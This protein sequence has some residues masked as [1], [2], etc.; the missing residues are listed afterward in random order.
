[1]I[2]RVLFIDS[3]TNAVA[4]IQD[5]LERTGNYEAAVFST[6]QAA[7]E[8]AAQHPPTV[9]V[10]ALNLRDITVPTLA[11]QLRR[12]QPDLP[13]IVRATGTGH[14]QLI[15]AL[16]PRGVIRGGYSVR[17]LTALLKKALQPS[18]PK[19]GA[20][21]PTDLTAG[22][23]GED[24][25]AFGEV[26]Q[27]I[28]PGTPGGKEDT[29]KAL[30]DWMR[31]PPEKKPPLPER[32]RRSLANMLLDISKG[33]D[34]GAL[35]EEEKSAQEKLFARLAAE[36][37]PMPTLEESGTVRDLI[38]IADPD[39]V[40]TPTPEP[41]AVPE[42]MIDVG[43]SLLDWSDLPEPFEEDAA[44]NTAAAVLKAL[45]VPPLPTDV[46]FSD[47]DRDLLAALAAEGQS[48]RPTE[49]G[50]PGKLF[51]PMP[52]EVRARLEGQTP[53]PEI[54]DMLPPPGPPA[55]P[56]PS[57]APHS[58]AEVA[59]LAVQLTQA[60]LQS[61]AQATILLRDNRVVASAGALPRD[62]I[63]ALA[64]QIDCAAV[65]R[66]GRLQIRFATL[67][68]T[69]NNYLIVATPTLDEMVLSMVFTDDMPLRNIRRQ[70][71]QIV[72]ALAPP[73]PDVLPETPPP[74]S[75]AQMPPV[76]AEAIESRLG[77]AGPVEREGQGG[78]T[79][80]ES[81]EATGESVAVDLREAAESAPALDP[82]TLARYA[83][84]WILRDPDAELD[85]EVIRAMSAWLEE[86]VAA[87]H[88]LA[89]QIDVQPDYVSAVIGV[90]PAE[91]PSQVVQRLMN[92]TAQRA[93]ATYPDLAPEAATL[94]ADAYYVVTPGR[95]L[96]GEEI[97]RFVSFQRQG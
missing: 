52:E 77:A 18:P 96:T 88:W 65:L 50:H 45:E 14:E 62:D 35:S 23:L 87:Q 64:K 28:E 42:E 82:A 57:T 83:C 47:S 92:E 81:R 1:M 26:L 8:Y 58:E 3:D 21:P 85:G 15:E 76:A 24:M 31:P 90:P 73:A 38:A 22:A 69:R 17:A 44:E 40:E 75:S 54:G 33:E 66:A 78:E 53:V 37:P 59:A 10:I 11:V 48:L 46:Q 2:T 51:I 94:W 89:D 55:S 27:S 4:R 95:P 79:P 56:A 71:R 86:I 13:L 32:R 6:G 7:L 63:E 67:P 70:A 20:A 36:E 29:F 19:P 5:A 49:T 60:S 97:S 39:F 16:N 84:A 30:V 93:L 72:E 25:A 9:A 68:Q 43:A 12:L 74:D 41:K 91:A 34:Q 61:S 80:L